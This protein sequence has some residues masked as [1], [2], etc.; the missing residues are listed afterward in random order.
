MIKTETFF[1]GDGM[2][3]PFFEKFVL[4]LRKKKS[5]KLGKFGTFRLVEMKARKAKDIN[6]GEEIEIPTQRT[7]KFKP[8]DTLKRLV[9]KKQV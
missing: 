8:S 1:I 4:A 5:I 6:T 3:Q 9:Q 7:V 2:D